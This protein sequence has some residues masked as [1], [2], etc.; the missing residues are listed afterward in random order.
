MSR[1]SQYKNQAKPGGSSGLF[2][3]LKSDEPVEFVIPKKGV[4]HTR[5]VKWVD[6]KSEES[7]AKDPEAKQRILV[8][9]YVVRRDADGGVDLR[10]GEDQQ[11]RVLELSPG[12][13]GDLC[14]AIDHP[15]VG[16]DEQIYE[17]SRTG[18]GMETR[19]KISRIDRATQPVLDRV[20]ALSI[21]DL[22]RYG[23][24][25]ATEPAPARETPPDDS[26]F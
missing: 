10:P 7:S 3:R 17:L 6:G 11:I 18:S 5:W 8:P 9:V 13:F 22:T 25:L 2:V 12:T 15:R 24:P 14:S 20:Q 19:Y 21:P 23:D 26:P 1:W 16:G 4:P